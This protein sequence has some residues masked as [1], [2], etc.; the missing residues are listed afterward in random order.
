MINVSCSCH[1]LM[2]VLR[3]LR[4]TAFSY[5]SMVMTMTFPYH[6]VFTNISSPRLVS[7][8]GCTRTIHYL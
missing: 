5:D 6:A 3:S 2:N 1:T 4:P 7:I 8:L